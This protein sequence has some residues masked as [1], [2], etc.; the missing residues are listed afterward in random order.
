[1]D[2]T[3]SGDAKKLEKNVFDAVNSLLLENITII[4]S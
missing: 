3:K 2:A 4:K 1:M